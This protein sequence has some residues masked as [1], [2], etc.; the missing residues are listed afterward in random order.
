[1]SVAVDAR[2]RTLNGASWLRCPLQSRL[3]QTCFCTFTGEL[4]L[5]SVDS[6][7]GHDEFTV[8]SIAVQVS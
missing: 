3:N 6:R 5:M 1:M 8:M 7:L 2:F 4:T